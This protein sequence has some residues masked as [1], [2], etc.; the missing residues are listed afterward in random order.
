MKSNYPSAKWGLTTDE[1]D[2]VVGNSGVLVHLVE[3]KT[4]MESNDSKWDISGNEI[5]R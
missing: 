4:K 5:K 1:D 3:H 2:D